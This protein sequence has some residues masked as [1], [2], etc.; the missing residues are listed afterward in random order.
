[1]FFH[2]NW[3][4]KMKDLMQLMHWKLWGFSSILLVTPMMQVKAAEKVQELPAIVVASDHIDSTLYAVPDT[5][6]TGFNGLKAHQMP[7]TLSSISSAIIADQHA[8]LLTDVVKNDASVGDGY[9]AIGYY[10]NFMVR[11]FA[12]DTASSYLINNNVVRGEQNIALENKQRV[13]ILKGISAIQSGM[14]TPAGV[15]NYVTKRPENIKTVT[16]DIDQYGDRTVSTD[17][18]GFVGQQQQLGYR[19]NLA[20]E[21]LHP[22]VENSKGERYFGALAL[23]WKI[24]DQSDV[25]LNVESQRQQQ[26]SVPGY[27]LLDASVVPHSVNKSQLLGYQ[28]W[29]K[30]VTNNSLNADI[31]YNYQINKQWK[32]SLTAARS[33]VV[34]DDYSAFPYGFYANGDYDIYDYR[35]PKDT[36]LTNQFKAQVEGQFTTNLLTHNMTVAVSETDKSRTRF[37]GINEYVG[38][39]NI[40]QNAIDF[41]PSDKTNLGARYKS[42]DSRQTSILFSDLVDLNANWS[43]LLSGRWIDLDEKAYKAKGQIRSTQDSKFLPQAAIIYK[44]SVSTTLYASYAKGLSDGGTAPWYA[45]NDGVTLAPRDSQQYELGLKQQ[46]ARALL[47]LSVFDLTQD[48]QYTNLASTFVQDGKQRN[49]GLD[50]SLSGRVAERFDLSSSLSYNQARLHGISDTTYQGHQVQNVPTWRFASYLSYTVPALDDRLRVLAGMQSS[51]SK[52]A[53][54]VGTVKVAGYSVFNA[55]ATYRATVFGHDADI[56]FNVNNVFNKQ[57]WRDVGGFMGDDYLF[58]GNPRTSQLSVTLHF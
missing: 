21:R 4:K 8:K 46:F 12:L 7:A 28:S 57:Y 24:N 1:M 26:R 48:N 35:S 14:S 22:Y 39:A 55:G 3:A 16:F 40:Y 37:K 18:G 45:S 44:P 9:A 41:A 50:L 27:Q 54:R 52:Y 2:L 11:G 30:P 17:L 25:A 15:V 10:P 51:A 49:R 19:V 34:I 13:E 5:E 31:S 43:V 33:R 6:L 38:T 23:D 36:Y 56:R 47:S 58:L 53:N 32:A 29:S 20:Q 42:L